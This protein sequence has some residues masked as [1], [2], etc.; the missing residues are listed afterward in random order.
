MLAQDA[1]VTMRLCRVQL[2]ELP[3]TIA[4]WRSR[5]AEVYVAAVAE[6][7]ATLPLVPMFLGI[8][9]D[10]M[11]RASHFWLCAPIDASRESKGDATKRWSL[12]VDSGAELPDEIIAQLVAFKARLHELL[13]EHCSDL[14]AKIEDEELMEQV[15]VT[16]QPA[17]REVDLLNAVPLCW[18]HAVHSSSRVSTP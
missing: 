10:L 16:G 15:Q 11:E 6:L 13:R 1:Y 18:Q 7:E 2:T 17:R 12:H 4:D 3:Q 14:L 5:A 9:D 8:V